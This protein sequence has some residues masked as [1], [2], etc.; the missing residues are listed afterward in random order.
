MYYTHCNSLYKKTLVKNSQ[1]GMFELSSG[2]MVMPGVTEYIEGV[3][4]LSIQKIDGE[5]VVVQP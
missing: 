2:V 4:G 5:Y 3:N 1:T